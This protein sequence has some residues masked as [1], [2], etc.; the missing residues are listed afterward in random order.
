MVRISLSLGG[1][2]LTAKLGASTLRELT[3]R[4]GSR[5]ELTSHGLSS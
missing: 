3:M 5:E 1:E 2:A 4:C